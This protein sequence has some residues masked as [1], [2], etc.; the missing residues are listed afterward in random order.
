MRARAWPRSNRSR[1][2][3]SQR[4]WGVA[5]AAAAV[6]GDPCQSARARCLTDTCAPLGQCRTARMSM[7]EPE[8]EVLAGV[9]LDR[10]L[11]PPPGHPAAAGAAPGPPPGGGPPSSGNGALPGPPAVPAAALKL[12]KKAQKKAAKEARKVRCALS[13][14]SSGE[15]WS[16][17]A[18]AHPIAS[19]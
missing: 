15:A 12:V 17:L 9:G 2:P 14:P 16:E 6:A 11:P 13:K 7:D 10:P 3:R 8:R 19:S 4:A 18:A 5:K 1:A